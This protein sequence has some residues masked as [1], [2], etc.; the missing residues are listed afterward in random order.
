MTDEKLIEIISEI[1]KNNAHA[2]I[3]DAFLIVNNIDQDQIDRVFTIMQED[4]KYFLDIG[5]TSR[6]WILKKGENYKP[7]KIWQKDW[8]IHTRNA[9]IT[10]AI[11]LLVGWWLLQPKLRE[12]SQEHERIN[13]RFDSL[14]QQM[15]IKTSLSKDSVPSVLPLSKS[16]APVK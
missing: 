12:W 15:N 5:A 13:N 10:G 9:I 7:K 2:K 1:V 4:K 11:S 6:S 3:D 14:I 8:F 16:D